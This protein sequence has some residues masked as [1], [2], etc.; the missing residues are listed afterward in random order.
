MTR[1]ATHTRLALLVAVDAPLHLQ[2]L[3]NIYDLLRCDITVTPQTLDLRRRMRTVAEEDKARQFVDELQRDLP[4][5]E[6]HVTT[7]ALHQSRKAGA[8][9]PLGILVAE[10]ALLLQGRVLL[11]IERPVLARQA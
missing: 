8:I 11:V 9:R 5:S 1:V 3:L 4:L 10:C 6:I 2:W 7:L